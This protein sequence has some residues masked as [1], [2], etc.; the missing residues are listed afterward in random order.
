[1]CGSISLSQEDK[2]SF[3]KVKLYMHIYTHM[4]TYMYFENLSL[5]FL[6]AFFLNISSFQK[7][8]Y[9][10]TEQNFNILLAIMR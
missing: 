1:M 6:E 3:F 8:Y 7:R 9:Y 4:Y 2:I 5:I 10:T